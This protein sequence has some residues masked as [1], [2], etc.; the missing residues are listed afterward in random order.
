MRK[1]D[2]F[3]VHV[4]PMRVVTIFDFESR[5]RMEIVESAKSLVSSGY[6]RQGR[7]ELSINSTAS[8]PTL[9][10]TVR[11]YYTCVARAF[12]SYL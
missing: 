9:L 12:F 10:A 3:I 7:F 2:R 4:F 1:N 5:G 8:M 11:K 6:T